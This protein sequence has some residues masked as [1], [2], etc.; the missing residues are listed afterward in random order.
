LAGQVRDMKARRAAFKG[1]TVRPCPLAQAEHT[2]SRSA[3][4]TV[5]VL[6][7]QR[8]AEAIDLNISLYILSIELRQK[9][10]SWQLSWL[11][12]WS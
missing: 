2:D 1:R 3:T 5:T 9:I 7:H 8:H 10:T 6:V 11:H 12:I 4:V